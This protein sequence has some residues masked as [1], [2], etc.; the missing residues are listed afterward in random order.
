MLIVG[1]AIQGC[2]GS[3]ILNGAL[4]I[5]AAAAPISKRPSILLSTL[6]YLYFVLIHMRVLLG[7]IMSTASIGQVIGPLIGG[8]LTQHASWRVSKFNGSSDG[9]LLTSFLVVYV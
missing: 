7:I 5:L 3:G 4:T 6:A 2:G 9:S 8:A 1:R